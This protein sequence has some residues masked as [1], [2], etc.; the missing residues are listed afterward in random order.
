MTLRHFQNFSLENIKRIMFPIHHDNC[1][2]LLAAI[3]MPN[4][5]IRLFDSWHPT[6]VLRNRATNPN[7]LHFPVSSRCFTLSCE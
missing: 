3:D 1:H 6:Y 4:K 5:S 2:W 7:R